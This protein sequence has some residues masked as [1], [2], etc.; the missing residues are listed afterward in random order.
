MQCIDLWSSTMNTD[1]LFDSLLS[2]QLRYTDLAKA[3]ERL[4]TSL[5]KD[6][7]PQQLFCDTVGNGQP[8]LTINFEKRAQDEAGDNGSPPLPATSIAAFLDKL[9]NSPTDPTMQELAATIGRFQTS[10]TFC[11]ALSVDFQNLLDGKPSGGNPARPSFLILFK[12]K[13]DN[14]LE[15]VDS[16]DRLKDLKDFI[17]RNIR[18]FFELQDDSGFTQR[19][20]IRG[21]RGS[22]DNLSA[23]PILTSNGVG[24]APASG[25]A[26]DT[27]SLSRTVQGAIRE[28]IGRVPKVSDTRSFLVAL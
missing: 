9:K 14:V 10:A 21:I 27:Y 25:G 23:Y 24:L 13:P 28:V 5:P 6:S 3:F 11:D 12:N 4:A 17:A 2:L 8:P 20:D 18:N 26:P 7:P 19:F 15:V 16:K 1:L 22:V